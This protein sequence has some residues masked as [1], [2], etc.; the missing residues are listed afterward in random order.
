M[1]SE[2]VFWDSDSDDNDDAISLTSTVSSVQKDEYELEA[3]LAEKTENDTTLYLVKWEGYHELRSTWEV[4]EH[5]QNEQTLHDWSDQKM[6]IS[7]GLA[8]R[9]DL[10]KWERDKE[11]LWAR[12][13]KRRQRRR[14]QKIALGLPVADLA[15]ED[16]ISTEEDEIDDYS[17][18]ADEETQILPW[19]PKEESTLLEALQR[20]KGPKWNSV[21]K[22]YGPKGIVNHNLEDRTETDVEQKAI[23]LKK[24]FDAS[25]KEFPISL[26]LNKPQDPSKDTKLGKLPT[27]SNRSSGKRGD[28]ADQ[29]TSPTKRSTMED[30]A[31]RSS[32]TPRAPK[33]NIQF[34]RRSDHQ[35]AHPRRKPEVPSLHVH[36]RPNK[37][38]EP[39]NSKTGI[40]SATT[41]TDQ[42][43]R[44]SG[45]PKS[46]SRDE[47]RSTQLGTVGRGPARAG[48]HIAK[49]KDQQINVLGNWG[50]Q[51]AKRRKSRYAP[52]TAHDIA[53]RPANTFKKFS[54][55]RKYELAGRREQAPDV[56]SLTF[57]NRKDGKPLP[58]AQT[59]NAQPVP[60]PFEMLQSRLSLQQ[61]ENPSI[62]DESVPEPQLT[63]PVRREL[64]RSQTADPGSKQE[65]NS[66]AAN[67]VPPAA[68]APLRRASMPLEMYT[69]RHSRG[70]PF[71]APVALMKPGQNDNKN[72]PSSEHQ[73]PF[74][75]PSTRHRDSTAVDI[76][77]TKQVSDDHGVGPPDTEPTFQEPHDIPP[78]I[79][80]ADAMP[81]KMQPREDGYAL[82][83]METLPATHLGP[84]ESRLLPTDVIAEILTG[85]EGQSTNTVIFRGLADRSLK[86]L[87]ITIRVY[88][89]QMHVWCKTMLTVG[90]YVTYFH[91]PVSYLGSGWI[92]PYSTST[93]RVDSLSRGLSDSASGGLFFA[94]EFSILIYPASCVGWEFIDQ[95]FPSVPP[96]T[97]LRF[98]MF[99]PWP[100]IQ[101]ELAVGRPDA[102]LLKAAGDPQNSPINKVFQTQ[103]GLDFHRLVAQAND[104]DGSKSK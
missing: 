18:H 53:T 92:V 57:V 44:A 8:P 89:K 42:L 29:P 37:A 70:Q 27:L 83:P 104:K 73:D 33:E 15:E 40:N 1:A 38:V 90:E 94:P 51:P 20:L 63:S 13:T 100:R 39:R 4:P 95:G 36:P 50:A 74:P 23:A 85:S 96:S 19:T 56:N 101:R 87:F 66:S 65:Q 86:H 78:S 46:V 54:T 69:E 81:I 16:E 88:P 22:L 48:P 84:Q 6:R 58:K 24:A 103:F 47:P 76:A 79:T 61:D 43:S 67:D 75:R 64:K 98:A 55:R 25:G 2:P 71:S 30:V 62:L 59:S 72:E 52:M 91:N 45:F 5:F 21:L 102:R 17:S 80:H 26:E 68:N 28:F 82:F 97:K 3:I 11:H 49:P 14:D 7:R 10:L 9:F 31:A 99:A 35:D 77:P 32:T 93:S 12:T 60:T 34:R 41:P